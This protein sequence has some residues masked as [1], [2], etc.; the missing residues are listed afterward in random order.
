MAS[1]PLGTDDDDGDDDNNDDDDDAKS[2]RA[3]RRAATAP[4]VAAEPSARPET[5]G[6]LFMMEKRVR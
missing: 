2:A 4:R 3:P 5:N 6:E 1:G